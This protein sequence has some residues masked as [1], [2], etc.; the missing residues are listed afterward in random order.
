MRSLPTCTRSS[1]GIWRAGRSIR[2]VLVHIGDYVDRGADTAGVLARLCAGSPIDHMP[3]VNVLGNHD[4]TMLH[5]LS[6]DRAA[7]T[8]WL[9]AGGVPALQS[10]GIDPQSAARSRGRRRCRQNIWIFSAT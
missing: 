2:R 7:A 5:A 1:L 9:F 8:D 10:Y 4:E 6:G 3:V